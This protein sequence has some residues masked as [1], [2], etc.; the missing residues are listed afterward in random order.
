MLV[1]PTDDLISHKQAIPSSTNEAVPI[2]ILYKATL[3]VE[4][5]AV[6]T[7]DDSQTAFEINVSLNNTGEKKIEDYRLEIEIPAATLSEY[8]T[9][10]A[11]V[12]SKRNGT[13]RLFRILPKAHNNPQIFPGDKLKLF[14][15]TLTVPTSDT[16]LLS[17]PVTMNLFIG[18]K[19]SDAL[20]VPLEKLLLSY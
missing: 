14:G 13:H 9:Y 4:C 10:A 17:L 12:V 19:V 1:I 6:H 8:T 18:D 3:E 11:E 7:P 15:T 16:R 20:S 2:T 5:N